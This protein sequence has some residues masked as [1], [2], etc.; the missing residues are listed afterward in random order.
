MDINAKLRP[1]YIA[2]LLYTS[3]STP[4]SNNMV[5]YVCL[6]IWA[7]ILSITWICGCFGPHAFV[8]PAITFRWFIKPFHAD[9]YACLLYTSH[10]INLSPSCINAV[11]AEAILYFML[12]VKPHKFIK[13]HWADPSIYKKDF[14]I[15]FTGRNSFC[16]E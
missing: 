5:A 13:S 8:P 16:W 11:T 14:L 12:Y 15:S 9:L 10:R 7:V 6:S 1:F 3:T 2:C 4:A